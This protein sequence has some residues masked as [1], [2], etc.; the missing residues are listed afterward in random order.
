M[1][2]FTAV[3]HYAVYWNFEDN[4]KFTEEMFEYVFSKLNMNKEVEI[5]DKE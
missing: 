5:K 3:E 2:E 4:M 1:Q